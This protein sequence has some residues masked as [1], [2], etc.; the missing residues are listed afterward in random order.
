MEI[1]QS[2]KKRGQTVNCK[3]DEIKNQKQKK[4]K[5]ERSKT[6]LEAAASK[7]SNSINSISKPS[8]NLQVLFLRII[9]YKRTFHSSR[10]TLSLLFSFFPSL[11]LRVHF[12]SEFHQ[13]Q[14]R[15]RRGQREGRRMH[16]M[17]V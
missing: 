5:T 15:K 8:M 1:K 6:I 13:R 4:N 11:L 14:R 12:L 3:R 2:I 7:R 17:H 10:T 9:I 16:N